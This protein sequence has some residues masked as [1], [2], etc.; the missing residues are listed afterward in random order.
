MTAFSRRSVLLLLGSAP[1]AGRCALAA[2]PTRRVAVLDWA[3]AE[4][5]IA[6][7][8]DPIAVVAAMDWSRFVIEPALPPGVADIGLE[9]QIN[10][11]LLAELRPELILTSPF[12][13]ELE[14]VLR[15]IAPTE[16]FSVF[17]PTRVPLECPRALMRTL[18]ARLGCAPQADE[19]LRR[20]DA[21]LE[22]YR[23]RIASL[24]PRPVLVISFLDARHARVYGGNGLFQNVLDRIGVV[25]A[26]TG[27]TNYWGFATVGIE[28][29]A[30]A[31]DVRLVVIDP[32]P[33]DARPTLAQ[34]PLWLSLPFVRAGQVSVL[35]PVLMFGAMPAAL[36]F[37]R[38]LLA[39]LEQ[40][41]A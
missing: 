9:Q 27:A 18:A 25:N 40:G 26:W 13:Q 36:R 15:R 37:A 19:F 32:V 8:H 4:T 2:P 35:P 29:L 21:L 7:G 22:S 1:A 16:R 14:P 24:R 33:V 23:G 17:E 28:S 34:S 10:Y 3:I 39:A 30:T 38:V 11:E 20:A 31:A 41:S 5:M 12:S 6:L